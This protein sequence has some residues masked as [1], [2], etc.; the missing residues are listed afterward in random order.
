M[1]TS[2]REILED[3]DSYDVC[4]ICESINHWEND[5]CHACGNNMHNDGQ[6]DASEVIAKV[7]E[8]I[9]NGIDQYS[10]YYV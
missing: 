4:V 2:L 10:D 7:N 8:E 9:E 6:A 1:K 5:E 3:P